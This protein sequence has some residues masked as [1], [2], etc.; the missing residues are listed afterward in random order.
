MEAFVQVVR[1]PSRLCSPLPHAHATY[2]EEPLVASL[3]LRSPA[4]TRDFRS[5]ARLCAA[6][7]APR[8]R[9]SRCATMT[10]PLPVATSVHPGNSAE[11]GEALGPC[12]L[13]LGVCGRRLRTV[14]RT[15]RAAPRSAPSQLR[16]SSESGPPWAVHQAGCSPV[17]LRVGPSSL[18]GPRVRGSCSRAARPLLWPALPGP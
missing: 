7:L 12:S 1:L 18:A 3:W 4:S 9:P 15:R 8:R 14:G 6:K 13:K 16:V 11:L 2:A 5:G 10:W 17:S